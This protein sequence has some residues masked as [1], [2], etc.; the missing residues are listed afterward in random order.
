[1]SGYTASLEREN[2]EL[3]DIIAALMIKYASR[4]STAE[5]LRTVL[6]PDVT[7]AVESSLLHIDTSIPGMVVIRYGAR[8]DRPIL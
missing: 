4:E 7:G 2:Q 6:N 8:R 5:A 3:R 1:M